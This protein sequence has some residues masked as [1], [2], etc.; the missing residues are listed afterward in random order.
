MIHAFHAVETSIQVTMAPTETTISKLLSRLEVDTS[1]KETTIPTHHKK[2]MIAKVRKDNY[3]EVKGKLT[4][5]YDAV[6]SKDD[7]SIVRNMKKIVPEFLSKNSQFERL[8][9]E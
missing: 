5:L 2:I 9:R 6:S 3:E 1:N 8:D 4:S 7:F